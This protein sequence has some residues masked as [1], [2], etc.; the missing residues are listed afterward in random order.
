MNNQEILRRTICVVR[1]VN[2]RIS[3]VTVILI[4]ANKTINV[5]SARGRRVIK[6]ETVSHEK[7]QTR[8]KN[9]TRTHLF[10]RHLSSFESFALVAFE[11]YRTA[12]S[13]HAG[14]FA[15]AS[16]LRKPQLKSSVWKPMKSGRLSESARTNAEF[17]SFWNVAH[18]KLLP[19]TSA[20]AVKIRHLLYGR[21]YLCRLKRGQ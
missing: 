6:N 8:Q 12:L 10:A 16:S 14:R 20:T 11:F 2:Y 7:L 21:K 5:C 4:T 9:V 19:F 15:G 18:G 13:D 1:A 3:S 17:G